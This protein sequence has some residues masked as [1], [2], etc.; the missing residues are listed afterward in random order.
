VAAHIFLFGGNPTGDASAVDKAVFR[1]GMFD[2]SFSC[3]NAPGDGA[4]G[5]NAAPGGAVP[6][7]P[8]PA[9]A[10]T[11]PSAEGGMTTTVTPGDLPPASGS[12][13]GGMVGTPGNCNCP[14][15]SELLGGNCVRYTATTCS[16]G[17]AVDALPQACRGVDEK[18]TCKMR[19]DGLKD[20]CCVLYDKM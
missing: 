16:N 2:G 9:A 6:S 13:P 11:V 3:R 1:C 15:N 12:C 18:L 5:K 19:Q 20:C 10:P 7:T 17:L 14:P 8:P 4:F